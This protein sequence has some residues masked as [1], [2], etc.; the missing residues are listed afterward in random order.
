MV[1]LMSMTPRPMPMEG[2]MSLMAESSSGPRRVDLEQDVV[3]VEGVD[4]VDESGPVAVLDDLAAVVAEA[5]VEGGFPR[6][7]GEDA[8]EGVGD[9][10]GRRRGCR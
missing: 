2:L 8:V 10:G 9:R 4:E 5:H 6:D 7:H 1:D 3:D